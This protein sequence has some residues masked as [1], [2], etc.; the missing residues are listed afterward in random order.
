MT[1]PIS[2]RPNGWSA[3]ELFKF[4]LLQLFCVFFGLFALFA[5]S[6]IKRVCLPVW[7]PLF[8]FVAV[9]AGFSIF[10]FRGL[11]AAGWLKHIGMFVVFGLAFFLVIQFSGLMSS[12][13]CFDGKYALVKTERTV[14]IRP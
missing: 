8:C 4:F 6:G 12:S 3:P 10:M 11:K 1:Q 13:L 14:P 2:K 5:E 7:F 9:N